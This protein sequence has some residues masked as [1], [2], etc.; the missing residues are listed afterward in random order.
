MLNRRQL[1]IKALQ[2]LYAHFQS[3]STDVIAT[4]RVLISNLDKLYELYVHQLSFLTAIQRYAEESLETSKNKYIPTPEDLNPNTRFVD[5]KF[6]HQI[7][8]NTDFLKKEANYKVNWSLATDTIH[9]IVHD[10]R[11][12]KEYVKY[13]QR[14]ENTYEYDKEI[15]LSLIRN[16]LIKNDVMRSF[17]EEKNSMWSEDYYMSLAMVNITIHSYE[18]S[19]SINTDL[20]TLYKG[21]SEY[22]MAE[23]KT[24]VIN[25]VHQSIVNQHK[26]DEI[27][28]KKSNNWEFDRIAAMDIILLR[29][30]MAEIFKFDSIP[31]KVTLNEMI[32]LAKHFSSPRSSV[33]VNGLLDRTIADGL[34]DNTIQKKGR[35]LVGQ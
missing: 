25:L 16:H 22:S 35:G 24:F 30:G 2:T 33:F 12:S 3:G 7:A 20:P 9:N 21:E 27:I 19:T 34:R 13:M 10:F 18:S 11:S 14:D 6:L 8:M 26:F 32:E 31:L 23:D 28:N 5:N 15:I 4:E 29:M 17:F 1:R